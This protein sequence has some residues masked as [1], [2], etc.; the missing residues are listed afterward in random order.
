MLQFII[1]VSQIQIEIKMNLQDAISHF[2]DYLGKVRDLSQHTLRNYD[3]DLHA[4]K[5]HLNKESGIKHI[6][7]K[8]IEKRH[9]RHY[10]ADLNERS[11]ARNT[12]LRHLS[13]LRS[14]YRYLVQQKWID[15]NVMGEIDT[16]RCIPSL[17]V[18]LTY[19]EV[20]CFLNQPDLSNLLG[21]RDRCIMELFYS[22]ALRLS[23]LIQLDRKDI[24][25]K[26]RTL[27]VK[28][29]GKKERLVPITPHAALWVKKYL[30]HPKRN[31]V[32]R[33]YSEKDH[34]A[35]FL[36]RWGSRLS[37]RSVDRLFKR[38]L[39]QSGLAATITPHTIR[40]TIA[41][42]WL[43]KGMDLKSI[44][45]LLGHRSLAAT[46]IYTKVSMR[47]KKEVYDRSHPHAQ[48]S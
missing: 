43:E 6:S 44:Q 4:F 42:H 17:P 25:F 5:N 31:M 41:T 46:T 16:P 33:S 36:N 15:H 22:S 40:H 18:S 3:L 9:I 39:T 21:Y 28:G 27:R 2:L 48:K 10:L 45:V 32:G 8:Q 1:F 24:D 7:L 14:F 34:S 38:Y 20:L 35:I 19:D 29:K 30:D 11:V 47:L 26:M 12:L 13:T 37:V 23:E